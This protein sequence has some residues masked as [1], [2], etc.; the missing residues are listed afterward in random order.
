MRARGGRDGEGKPERGGDGVGDE[1]G[2]AGAHRGQLVAV[3]GHGED[4]VE[5]GPVL[6]P[7]AVE[8][9]CVERAAQGCPVDP[10]GA[11]EVAVQRGSK[12]VDAAQPRAVPDQQL[13]GGPDV[14]V[15]TFG[16]QAQACGAELAVR[17]R[18]SRVWLLM[19]SPRRRCGRLLTRSR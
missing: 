8:V 13:D 17:R 5:H 15:V 19:A 12:Q 11:V 9:A 3:G 14:G 7:G 18:G 2:V 10:V 16:P 1:A 6:D 4:E